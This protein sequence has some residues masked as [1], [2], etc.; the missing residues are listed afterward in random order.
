VLTVWEFFTDEKK[1]PK[2]LVRFRESSL[3][4]ISVACVNVTGETPDVRIFASS[5]DG[6]I[7]VYS[8]TQGRLIGRIKRTGTAINWQLGCHGNLICT[9]TN[10][11]EPVLYSYTPG[12]DAKQTVKFIASQD[13]FILATA[14]SPD[15]SQIAVGYAGKN[16]LITIYDAKSGEKIKDLK[17]P[18]DAIRKLAF[19]H[20]GKH[21]FAASQDLRVHLFEIEEGKIVY[22][23][24]G[25]RGWVT[26]VSV[27]ADNQRVASVSTDGRLKIWD[28][29]TKQNL[30]TFPHD[31]PVWDCAYSPS[32]KYV[33]TCCED[34]QLYVYSI[35]AR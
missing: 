33:A 7:R 3:G 27:S 12:E 10:S 34:G 25:H 5:L 19:D 23:L 9:G 22:E 2:L 29:K 18:S 14:F 13:K 26:S 21:L 30:V 6:Y 1:N 17:G 32:G 4:I 35:T 28:V 11:G 15:G 24:S 20:T 31:G 8:F 16:P